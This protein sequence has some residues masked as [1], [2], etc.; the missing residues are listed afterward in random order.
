MKLCECGCG[1]PAPIAKQTRSDRGFVKGQPQRF[2]RGHANVQ[3]REDA[4]LSPDDGSAYI[5]LTR[6]KFALVDK[7]DW[8]W[9]KEQRW[10]YTTDGYAAGRITTKDRSMSYMH[11]VI[12]DAPSDKMVD[13]INGDKLD[14]RRQNLRL[15]SLPENTANQRG[16]PGTSRYKGV[17]QNRAGNWQVRIQVHR[18]Q[19]QLGTYQDEIEA[20][21]VYDTAAREY[22]GEFARCNF[23]L[24]NE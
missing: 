10:S 18:K 1:Q 4:P 13:H 15:C 17:Q 7:S 2:M 24:E 16:R 8:E 21:K 14:N 23:P 9:L 3:A 20:A 22:F 5:P 6:G 12:M 19:I 11:R